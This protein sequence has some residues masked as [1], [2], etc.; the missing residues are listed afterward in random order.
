MKMTAMQTTLA[1]LL[2]ALLSLPALAIDRGDSLEQAAEH[3]SATLQVL[4]VASSGWAERNA[5]GQPQGVT[6][7]LMQRFAA[8]LAEHHG[9]NVQLHFVEETD[10]SR[11]YARVR[12]AD[13]GVFGLG[14]VTITEPRRQELAFSPP[15]V[16]NVAVLIGPP[17]YPEA[18]GA[19]ELPEA[20][21][22]LSAL[23]FQGTL[24]E[25]RLRRLAATHWPEMPLDFSRSNDEILQ[26]VA[27]GSHFAYIDGY[28][29]FRARVEGLDIRRHP[30]LDDP[31][32]SF[33]IIMPLGNDWQPLL[34]GFFQADG[35]LLQSAW[36]RDLLVQHLGADVAAFLLAARDQ[37]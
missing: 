14:N 37:P 36:Y 21:A 13:G 28:N 11:F 18:Q 25:D 32:E 34:Q 19:A 23:A 8:W 17:G 9:L 30:Q 4:W 29:Y 22:G 20:L 31:S 3:G 1:G 24:H 16:A 5:L 35:G 15:Y 10:W 7:A 27:A 2:V 33:G 6:I 26:A 12:E